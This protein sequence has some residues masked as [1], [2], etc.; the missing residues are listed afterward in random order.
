MSDAIRARK[1]LEASEIGSVELIKEMKIIKG[2][3]KADHELPDLVGG[4]SGEDLIVEEFRKVYQNLYNSWDTSTGMESIKAH[5][6]DLISVDEGDAVA[7]AD[8]ITG[9]VLKEAACRMK[10]GK[11]DVSGSYTSDAILNAPDSFFDL[12]APVFRSW[13]IHGTGKIIAQK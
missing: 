11:G 10:P 8:M 3:K 6:K 7:E 4:V 12:L 13:L 2:S 1:L 9:A 5:L